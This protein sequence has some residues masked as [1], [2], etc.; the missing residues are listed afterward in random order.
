MKI[1][2]EVHLPDGKIVKSAVNEVTVDGYVE[3]QR[4]IL[5]VLVEDGSFMFPTEGNEWIFLPRKI[6][7]RSVFYM[8]EIP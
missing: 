8:R 2:Y 1:Q 5:N 7:N 3:K 6:I 4:Y